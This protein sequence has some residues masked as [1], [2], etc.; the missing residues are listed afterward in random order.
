MVYFIDSIS[1]L[2]VRVHSGQTSMEWVGNCF[3]LA[4]CAKPLEIFQ[5]GFYESRPDFCYSFILEES[6]WL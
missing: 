4:R 2:K 3:P 1:N 6:F 5:A